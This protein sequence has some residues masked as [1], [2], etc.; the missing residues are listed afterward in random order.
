MVLVGAGRMGHHHARA[1]ARGT[2]LRLLA[3]VDPVEPAWAD[4]PWEQDLEGVLRRL[5]P[6][7]AI[8]A[9]PSHL[10]AAIARICLDG[11][12]H[13]LLE[14]PICPSFEEAKCLERDF[15][16]AGK[17]LFGGHSERFHPVFTALMERL[18][19]SWIH[20]LQT[21]RTGPA[22]DRA[23][24]DDVLLDLA[25]H[26][27]DLALRFLGP[28]EAIEPLRRWQGLEQIVLRS[29][30]GVRVDLRSGYQSGRIRSWVLEAEGFRIDADFLGRTL[31]KFDGST[32][33][34]IPI[35]AGDPLE[36]EHRTFRRFLEGRGSPLDLSMQIE[37]IGIL[38]RARGWS[39]R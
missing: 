9:V 20:S 35:G 5:R 13:V 32:S 8:V 31:R 28:L 39:Q 12:C 33:Q 21:V 25:V 14:K 24:P 18:D 3:V 10:H 36:L 15:H 38:E 23:R 16:K 29:G 22:P 34:E 19:P 2:A 27:V 1:L 4:V 37:A 26:D 7:A 30:R 17:L 6:D 11:G